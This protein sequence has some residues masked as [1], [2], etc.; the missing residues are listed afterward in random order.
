[1]ELVE[2]CQSW[3]PPGS[4]ARMCDGEGKMHAEWRAGAVDLRLPLTSVHVS[5]F[6]SPQMWPQRTDGRHC[7]S[8]CRVTFVPGLGSGRAE[9]RDP[10][11]A[12]ALASLLA[13]QQWSHSICKNQHPDLPGPSRVAVAT[14]PLPSSRSCAERELWETWFSSASWHCK[15]TTPQSQQLWD[16]P[17]WDCSCYPSPGSSHLFPIH[18]PLRT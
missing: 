17:A 15:A 4:A 8:G 16:P 11:E 5:P 18:L 6:P 2:Q 1:M 12:G 10:V 7:C 14:A 9:G 13:H 3:V